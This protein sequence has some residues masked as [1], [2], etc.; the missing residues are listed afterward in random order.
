MPLYGFVQS[1]G[2]Y[3]F[4]EYRNKG[5]GTLLNLMRIDITKY[6]GF[7]GIMCLVRDDNNHQRS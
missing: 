3:V 6:C 5:I 4:S 7:N 2:S 1:G